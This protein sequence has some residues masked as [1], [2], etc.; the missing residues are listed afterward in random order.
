MRILKA[1]AREK[2]KYIAQKFSEEKLIS[3]CIDHDRYR[4]LQ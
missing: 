1:N 3:S 4:F 2:I